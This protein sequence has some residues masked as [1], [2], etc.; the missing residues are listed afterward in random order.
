MNTL[1]LTDEQLVLVERALDFYSRIGIG[2]F[3]RI[4]DHPSFE[5]TVYEHCTPKKEIEV[6][7]RTPQGEVLEIKDGKALIK[8]SVNKKT[9][10][11]QDKPEWKKLKDVKLST[12]YSRYHQIM[13][14]VKSALVQP[15]N[16]LM[17]D[18]TLPQHASWGIYNQNVD[19]TC[20]IAFDIVQVIRHERWKRYPNRSMMTVDASIHLSH[21]KDDSSKMIKCEMEKPE[22]PMKEKTTN[23]EF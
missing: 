2:Q 23:L 15:R 10:H 19:D 1:H 9:G 16:M 4:T 3:E 6:G 8:G 5:R 18:P 14:S 22:V 12:D 11:W 13:D 7:D 17:C 20:R 21:R